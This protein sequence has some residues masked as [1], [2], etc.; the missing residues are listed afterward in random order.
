MN[1][2][3]AIFGRFFALWAILMFTGTM[4]VYLIP[5]YVFIHFRKEP[6]K[7]HAF[8]RFA[9]IWMNSFI[10]LSFCRLKIYGREHF[11]KGEN[12]I[13][14][15]NH[16]SM[17]DI[18][19]SSPAIPGGNKTIA[20]AEM[21]KIPIFGP[22]YTTGS[23]LVK[24]KDDASRKDS[25]LK[26]KEILNMGLHMCIYPEGT[27]NRTKELLAPF[28]GGAFKLAM[29]SGKSLLPGIILH[30]RKILDAKKPFFFMPGKMEMHFLPPIPVTAEDTADSLKKKSIEVMT[31][32]L[33]E[34]Q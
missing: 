27:R 33:K 17:M 13:V 20:K 21:A 4:F 29:D 23:V 10:Y 15:C 32:F 7:S 34:H 9:R 12:Y 22:L 25:Y 8:I 24:R 19:I 1:F 30:T 11:K 16:N 5:Y 28:H 3:R 18:P 14:I 31:A 6:S 2:L 26:M